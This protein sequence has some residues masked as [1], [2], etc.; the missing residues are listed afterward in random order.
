MSC[1]PLP[2]S[3]RCEIERKVMK[4]LH[5]VVSGSSTYRAGNSLRISVGLITTGVREILKVSRT[6]DL[7][8]S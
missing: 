6:V 8:T 2:E 5:R 3:V 4:R 1:S 7:K